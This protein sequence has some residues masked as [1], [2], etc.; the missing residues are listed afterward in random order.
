MKKVLVSKS[1]LESFLIT[2][3]LQKEKVFFD[4]NREVFIQKNVNNKNKEIKYV[5]PG[6]LPKLK[7]V[8]WKDYKYKRNKNS[9]S[10]G[11]KTK[12]GGIK[13]GNQVHHEFEDYVN[14]STK[15]FKKKYRTL[16]EY[17]E[18]LIKALRIYKLIPVK[19]EIVV[20]DPLLNVA[21]RIDLL[22]RDE[23][24]NLYLLEI[25]TGMDGYF[26][27]GSSMFMTNLPLN[28]I[29]SPKNQAV[30]QCL[31]T[32]QMLERNYDITILKSYVIQINL[33]GVHPVHVEKEILDIKEKQ[34]IL[35]KEDLKNVIFENFSF[36]M[37]AK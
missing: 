19:S 31:L 12:F 27:N 2:I 4:E 36:F 3:E 37:I 34:N 23:F 25:K 11:A 7:S 9:I 8:F 18:K 21:T 22:A 13:R 29:N 5:I 10:S 17:T 30:F 15:D 6:L 20:F 28:I 24:Y 14:L 32:K 35:L 16:H 26:E 1:K 33:N